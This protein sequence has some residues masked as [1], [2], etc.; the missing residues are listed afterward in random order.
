MPERYRKPSKTL[1]DLREN[2]L[3]LAGMKR[4]A[5]AERQKMQADELELWE[6][7]EA[8]RLLIIDYAA[9]KKALLEKCDSDRKALI[10][11]RTEQREILLARRRAAEES[12]MNRS[13]VVTVKPPSLVPVRKSLNGN[14]ALLKSIVHAQ[15]PLIGGVK[16]PPLRPPNVVEVR[17][18]NAE[19]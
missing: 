4:F 13:H 8:Q 14:A 16:L 9:A 10:A 6:T 5:E 15:K 11:K 1:L 17:K 18:R 7:Q 3:M 2:T 12:V 19:M